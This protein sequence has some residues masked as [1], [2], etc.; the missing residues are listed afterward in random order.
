[1]QSGRP[2]TLEIALQND[3]EE[4][5]EA[6]EVTNGCWI[7]GKKYTLWSDDFVNFYAKFL[8][9]LTKAMMHFCINYHIKMKDLH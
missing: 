8:P 5:T 2:S 1:M 7:S 9:C 3:A 4:S 6:K